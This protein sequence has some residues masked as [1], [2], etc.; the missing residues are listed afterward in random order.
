MKLRDQK[1]VAFDRYS[2]K[3]R[4]QDESVMWCVLSWLPVEYRLSRVKCL[5]HETTSLFNTPV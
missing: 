5:R 2:Q 3:Q 4:G 1:I